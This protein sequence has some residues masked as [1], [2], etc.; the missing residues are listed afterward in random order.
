MTDYNII[1][2]ING[3]LTDKERKFLE[4]ALEND[5]EFKKRFNFYHQIKT[6][7]DSLDNDEFSR[8][9]LKI[10]KKELPS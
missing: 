5:A 1:K 2:Y 10:R 7:S 8:M 9:L 4:D 6:A 3:K